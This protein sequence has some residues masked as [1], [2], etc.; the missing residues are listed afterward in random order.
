MMAGL[1]DWLQEAVG[2]GGDIVS[3][4]NPMQPGPPPMQ[5][6]P[7]SG[8]MEPRRHVPPN[9]TMPMPP[10]QQAGQDAIPLP[11]PGQNPETSFGQGA[12]PGGPPLPPA[13]LEAMMGQGPPPGAP[14][15]GIAQIPPGTDPMM[16]SPTYPPNPMADHARPPMPMARP[17][18]APGAVPPMPPAQT[19]NPQQP[20]AVP[21]NPGAS[22]QAA[23]DSYRKAGGTMMNPGRPDIGGEQAQARSILGRSLGL[24]QNQENTLRGS[25]GAGLKAAG[26]NSNK[27][28]GAALM[29]S[30]GAAIEGGKNA[31]DKTTDQQDKVLGRAIQ[32]KTADQAGINAGVN[33]RLAE[34]RTRLAEEQTKMAKSGGKDSV[35]NSQQQLYLRGIGLVNNDPEVKLAKAAYEAAVKVGD[36]NSPEVKAAKKAHEDLVAAK[37]KAHLENLGVDPKIADKL[38]KQPGMSQDNPVDTKGMTQ[39]KLNALPSGAY[40][41]TPDGKVLQKKQAAAPAAGPNQAAPAQ[42][43]TSAVQPPIPPAVA[44]ARAQA[45]ADDEED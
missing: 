27:G 40:I 32:S 26:E 33:N 29:G 13:N 43:M 34:A 45:G 17:P 4:G 2:G 3:G 20:P 28:K 12:P 25:L 22:T 9:P 10:M 42:S 24:N 31:D 6:N 37:T 21:P 23:I 11:Q 41:R 38:G 15:G 44:N 18:G 1:L 39:D 5:M 30:A 16:G 36:P 7:Y 19:V 35:M 14:P 8:G